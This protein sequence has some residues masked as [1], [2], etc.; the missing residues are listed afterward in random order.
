MT[1]KK[2]ITIVDELVRQA[3]TIPDRPFLIQNGVVYTFSRFLSR[4][5]R[6]ASFLR[7]QQLESGDRIVLHLNDRI[8]HLTAYFAAMGLGIIVVH[9]YPER[10]RDTVQFLVE[11]VDASLVVTDRQLDWQDFPCPVQFFPENLSTLPETWSDQRSEV[12]YMMFTSGTT[13]TPKGVMTTQENIIAVTDTLIRMADMRAEDKEI[14]F[15]PLGST[16]G[17]GHVHA[18]VRR[19]AH[20]ILLPFFFSTMDDAQLAKLLDIVKREQING[21]LATPGILGRFAS[22]HKEALQEKAKHVRFMLAN[23]TPMPKARV[24]T[25]LKLLP[26]TRFHTYYGSTEA[27][28]SVYQCYNDHDPKHYESAGLPAQGVEVFIDQ[29]DAKGRGEVMVRGPHVM[30]GYWNAGRASLTEDHAFH[31]GDYGSF[32]QEGFLTIQGR[33]KDNINVDGMK[34]MPQEIEAVISNHDLV[35]ACAVTG[36][37]DSEK[38]QRVGAAIV[39]HASVGDFKQVINTLH[40]YCQ[41]T[42]DMSFKV[43]YRWLIVKEIPLTDLGKVKRPELAEMILEEGLS[44]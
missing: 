8:D 21:F 33:L 19:G 10:Q 26:N 43:P 4:A 13:G 12:A 38:F 22:H 2:L 3:E 29:P 16:G 31:T 36:I 34:C 41:E 17:L 35:R 6:M 7:S 20:A 30:A 25:L 44:V 14:I 15:M 24:A 11:H 37:A 27:S 5:R 40:H 23:V 28:R 32:D 42:L 1:S 39:L 9:T 18:L